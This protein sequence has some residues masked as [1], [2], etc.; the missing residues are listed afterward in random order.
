VRNGLKPGD[1]VV[2]AG[3]AAL[4]DGSLVQVLGA[5]ADKVQAASVTPPSKTKQ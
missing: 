4:R 5:A 2:I 1:Q 3:K